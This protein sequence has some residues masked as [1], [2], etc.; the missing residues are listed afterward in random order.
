MSNTTDERADIAGLTQL[1]KQYN[2]THGKGKINIVART[3]MELVLEL[4]MRKQS[5]EPYGYDWY[6]P[7]IAYL[8]N[9]VLEPYPSTSSKQYMATAV[10]TIYN[11]ENNI[12]YQA[13]KHEDFVLKYVVDL[14]TQEQYILTKLNQMLVSFELPKVKSRKELEQFLANLQDPFLEVLLFVNCF[15][16]GLYVKEI[17]DKFTD[18]YLQR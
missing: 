9:T 3:K 4:M 10:G 7:Y 6:D 15:I 2:S 1:A 11:V 8:A 18:L 17:T 14:Q 5:V 13:F 12:L 16:H